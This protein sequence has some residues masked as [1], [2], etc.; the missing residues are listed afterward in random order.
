MQVLRKF[1]P[2]IRCSMRKGTKGLSE[3]LAFTTEKENL[4]LI[5]E[6]KLIT[7]DSLEGVLAVKKSLY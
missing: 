1:Y 2:N 4:P 7:K 3:Y 6:L 5:T